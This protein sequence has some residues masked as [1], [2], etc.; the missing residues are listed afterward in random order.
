MKQQKVYVL[1]EY[2]APSH[3]N[4]LVELGNQRGFKVEFRIFNPKTI[5][6]KI[7]RG[8]FREAFDS[9]SF[10]LSL[11]FRKQQKIVLGIAPFNKLL[12]P[13]AYI[14]KKHKVYYHTSYTFW[15][16]SIM[17]HPT[18]SKKVI[19]F[20]HK[21]IDS[22]VSHIF[23]VSKKTKDELIRNKFSVPEKISIVNHSYN[24]HIAPIEH[25][26]DNTFIYVG[27]LSEVKGIPELLS[28]FKD[29]PEAQLTI[30]GAGELEP[31]VKKYA[32]KYPNI[33]YLGYIHGLS[34]LIPIY[35]K[36]SFLI[37]NSQRTTSWE[38]L[39]GIAII[40][41]MA[42]GCVPITTDHSGPKEIITPCVD[43]FISKEK[44][45]STSIDNAISFTDDV[46][47]KLR[48]NTIDRGLSFHAST[49]SNKWKKFLE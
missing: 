33:M 42:C 47:Q 30:V 29:R 26:K 6:G 12:Y 34:N 5:A 40:E 16:G 49:M 41:G 8:K 23:A 13:L 19:D 20:W 46:F 39:F 32:E 15:D 10:L 9:V 24:E 1:H 11:P 17:A 31:L 4:A 18:S 43:G 7:L 27:R 36:H 45:I 25:D 14:L 48:I 3:Y 28:I 21:F 2:G 44:E 22:K 37:M 35:Q 38:E